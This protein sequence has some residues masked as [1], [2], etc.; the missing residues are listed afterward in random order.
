MIMV[1]QIAAL[2]G[3]AD[4]TAT[5]RI[6][7]IKREAARAMA[8]KAGDVGPR[9]LA[10]RRLLGRPQRLRPGSHGRETLIAAA[11][12][13]GRARLPGDRGRPAAV[14]DRPRGAPQCHD[15]RIS[16]PQSSVRVPRRKSRPEEY[17][18]PAHVDAAVI[19]T[20]AGFVSSLP[21]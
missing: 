11:D 5:Q 14:Q 10:P 8:A 9:F 4:E 16:A 7:A 18:R 21:K 6:D 15:P 13:A 3:P 12:L 19:E 1:E 2:D 20:L 17:Q